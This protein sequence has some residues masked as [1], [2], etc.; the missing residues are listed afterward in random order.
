MLRLLDAAAEAIWTAE[1]VP[2]VEQRGRAQ[3]YLVC[4]GE[5]TKLGTVAGDGVSGQVD[6]LD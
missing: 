3:V 2:A 6:K 1:R 4:E 5:R